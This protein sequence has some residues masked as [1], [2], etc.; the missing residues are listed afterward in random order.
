MLL[1]F[2]SAPGTCQIANGRLL[3]L[4]FRRTSPDARNI[5]RFRKSGEANE[6]LSFENVGGFGLTSPPQPGG[7]S[8]Q[9]VDALNAMTILT[10]L[11]CAC[12]QGKLI[13][14]FYCF[15]INRTSQGSSRSQQRR[16]A[17]HS[18]SSISLAT[19]LPPDTRRCL[20]FLSQR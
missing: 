1:S 8:R 11:V 9:K 5:A 12:I 17:V 10:L 13:R 2:K 7:I 18:F 16:L 14:P 20:S 4:P 6:H 3:Q 15:H 19:I